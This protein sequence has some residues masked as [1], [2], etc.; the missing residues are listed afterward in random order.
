MSDRPFGLL[1]GSG[2]L[3]EIVVEKLQEQN[4]SV[5]ACHLTPSPSRKLRESVDSDKVFPPEKFGEI[6]EFLS[7]RDV[8]E[9]VM[10]GSVDR[11]LLFEDDRMENA[12]E[13]V[14]GRVDNQSSNQDES[15]LEAA[16]EVLETYGITVRGVDTILDDLLTP[17]GHLGGP[18]LRPEDEKTLQC[19]ADI[20]PF[21]SDREVGQS[22]L[23]KR[24]SVVAVEAAEGTNET[25][26]RAGQLAGSGTVMLKSARTDQDFRLDVPVVGRE[27]IDN[28]A[29]IEANLLAVEA[30][31]TLWIEREACREVAGEADITLYGWQRPGRS[32]GA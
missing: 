7:D 28:L 13:V 4:R 20:G 6:P 15:L 21:L 12:D 29:A 3:P 31:K 25:I 27:T 5:V 18:S 9:L 2:Q 11:S 1:A 22:I 16:V 19:L 32:D 26:R 24:Q 14:S 8:R 17:V 10:V 30:R 23:G